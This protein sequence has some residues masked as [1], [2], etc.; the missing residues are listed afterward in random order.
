MKFSML[1]NLTIASWEARKP[2]GLK[3]RLHMCLHAM[4]TQSHSIFYYEL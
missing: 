3:A 4:C 2:E 1:G